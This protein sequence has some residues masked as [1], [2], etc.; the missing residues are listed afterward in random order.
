[1]KILITQE[2][3]WL[4]RN[5]VQQH[6]LAEKL[7]LSGHQIRVIDYEILWR[8]QE[9]RGLFSRRQTFSNVSKIY[10]DAKVILIRPG[11]IKIPSL[12][13]VS[14]VLSHKREIDRQMREFVPDVIVGFGILNS[15]L[16]VKTAR[17]HNIP[18]I[19]YWIDV[20]HRLIPFKPFQPI[21]KMV[22]S[23][24]LK[25][26][27]RILV[28]NDKL[29]DYVIQMGASPERTWRSSNPA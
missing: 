12:D 13:Y 27:D 5:P 23:R 24:I 28:I 16:S 3:D 9:Q 6:H 17:A 14:L 18:F 15:Y 20:L 4:K 21:G 29:G 8:T 22:E 11:I 25:Q 19:Y 1:M 7:S 2:T 26:A 10:D